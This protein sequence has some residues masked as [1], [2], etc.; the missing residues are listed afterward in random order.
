MALSDA[1]GLEEERRLFYV[2][3]TRARRSLDVYVPLRFHVNRHA[4]D[5]RNVWAQPSR[6]LT[7]AV[8]PLVDEVTHMRPDD[9]G[10]AVIKPID[11][12]ITVDAQLNGLWQ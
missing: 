5:D 2:A 9:F 12:A 7:G 1:A 8:A 11:T 4:R 10:V 6:F 3:L